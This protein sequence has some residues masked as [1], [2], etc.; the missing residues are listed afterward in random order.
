[1]GSKANGVYKNNTNSTNSTNKQI[2]LSR[3]RLNMKTIKKQLIQ[4]V[5]SVAITNSGVSSGTVHIH[6]LTVVVRPSSKRKAK[7]M[8]KTA[9]GEKITVM[10]SE[11]AKTGAMVPVNVL[12]NKPVVRFYYPDSK[13]VGRNKDRQVVLFCA[14]EKYLRGLE[15]T[16]GVDGKI[17]YQFKCYLQSKAFG[18]KL[19]A[20]KFKS[21]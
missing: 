18:V 17:K 3:L 11:K 4:S 12:D 7:A 6:N 1:M 14:D 5:K 21:T 19:E 13:E 10:G 8:V 9:S 16:P 20:F 2:N 15:M